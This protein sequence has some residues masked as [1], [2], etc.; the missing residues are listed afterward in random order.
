MKD[1][2]KI[3]TEVII[4]LCP[5]ILLNIANVRIIFFTKTVGRFTSLFYFLT[6]KYE[7]LLNL[8]WFWPWIAVN[9]LK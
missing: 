3:T 2:E 4:C 1:D 6:N 5:A 9:M 8:I 7:I